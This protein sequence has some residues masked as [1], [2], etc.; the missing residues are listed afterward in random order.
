MVDWVRVKLAAEAV[1]NVHRVN[2]LRASK[3]HWTAGP[4]S[5]HVFPVDLAANQTIK[6]KWLVICDITAHAVLAERAKYRSHWA[7]EFEGRQIHKL[8]KKSLQNWFN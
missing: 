3:S 2:K 7:V 4:Q 5:N 6:L 1:V 8:D